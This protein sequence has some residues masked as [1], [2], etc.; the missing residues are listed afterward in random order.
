MAHPTAER[1]LRG[2]LALALLALFG[3]LCFAG[4]VALGTWQVHRLAWKEALIAHANARVH[5]P[6][7]PAPGP[8]AWAGLT[9]DNAAYRH[10][11]LHGTWLGGR[12]TR[13]W[14]A[15]ELG[16]GYWI[17]TPLRRD[18]G[19]LVLVNRGFAPQGWCDL[20]GHCPAP[21]AGEVTVTGLLR[22]SEPSSWLRRNAPATDT[23][24]T[25]DVPAIAKARGLH[26]VAPYFVDADAGSA[27]TWPR[28][29]LTVVHFPNHHLNYLVTWYLL[30]LMVLG[31][32]VYVARDEYRLRRRRRG[33][34]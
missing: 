8:A 14:T 11:R 19:S 31:A 28:G 7:V 26:G 4:F 18:D 9:V 3:L 20:A 13:V 32:S 10:V 22:F 23:W 12:Q 15:T 24:Y 21:P 5:A 2:P 27:A 34:P 16:S 25:R 30:A 6:P 1:E 33:A 29:G 17:L